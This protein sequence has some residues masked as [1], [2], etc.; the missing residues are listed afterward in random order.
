MLSASGAWTKHHV[1]GPDCPVDLLIAHSVLVG[2][3]LRPFV[4]LNCILDVPNPLICPTHQADKDGHSFLLSAAFPDGCLR[5]HDTPSPGIA[6]YDI[7]CI[8]VEELAPRGSGYLYY[9]IV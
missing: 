1:V 2:E 6:E 3:F 4:T 8:W 9:Q 5:L 7:G